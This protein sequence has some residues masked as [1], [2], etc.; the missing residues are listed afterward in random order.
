MSRVGSTSSSKVFTDSTY[1]TNHVDDTT[2]TDVTYIGKEDSGGNWLFKKID[3]SGAV[4]VITCANQ[5]N[6]PT[7]TSYDDAYAN[8]VTL[9]YSKY[10]EV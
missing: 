9:T 7:V 1:Q 6:N 5:T 8:R 10:S 3:Q 2:T 4:V